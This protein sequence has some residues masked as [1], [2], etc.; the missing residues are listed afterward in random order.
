MMR[1]MLKIFFDIRPETKT[2]SM[3]T[4]ISYHDENNLKKHQEEDLR[5]YLKILI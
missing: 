4:I 3:L 1:E 5:G 2:D